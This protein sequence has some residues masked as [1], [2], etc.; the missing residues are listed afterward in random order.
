M[1]KSTP[2]EKAL[3]VAQSMIGNGSRNYWNLFSGLLLSQISDLLCGHPAV[4]KRCEH[5]L[6]GNTEDV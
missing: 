4:E 1:T 6:A 3:M 2:D 5:Q